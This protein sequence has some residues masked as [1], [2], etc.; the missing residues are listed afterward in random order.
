[1]GGDGKRFAREYFW[2]ALALMAILLGSAARAAPAE[3][4]AGAA[5]ANGERL[6]WP[7]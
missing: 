3:E 7:A 2:F 4:A 6:G 5:F 1:M